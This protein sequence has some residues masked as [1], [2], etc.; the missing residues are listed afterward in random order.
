MLKSGAK[1]EIKVTFRP[2][3]AKV[4]VSTAVFNFKEGNNSTQRV[5]KMSGIGKFPFVS[6]NHERLDFEQLTVGKELSKSVTLR[7]YSLVKAEYTLEPVNDD[8][9]DNSVILSTMGGTIAP[10]ASATI[11]VT[12]CPTLVGQFTSRQ[13]AIKVKGGNELKLVTIGQSNG[14]DVALSTQS[15]HFGEVQLT[16]STNRLLNIINDSDQATSFQFFND[17]TNIFSFSKVEGTIQPHSQARIIIEFFPQATRNYYERVFCVVRSHQVLYVDLMGT[18]FDVLTKPMPLM[19]RHVD[20]YRH[21]VIMGVH[22]KVRKDKYGD[23][24]LPRAPLITT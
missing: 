14:V 20:I 13:F 11:L 16:H 7:N 23:A 19:Q 21:K 15:I 12:F 1:K 22:N 8:G 2:T 3:E 9:K 18:C 24:T 5:L 17:R 4:T 10:G 6:I